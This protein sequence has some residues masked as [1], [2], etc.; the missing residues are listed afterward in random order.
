ML[1]TKDNIDTI[2]SV[3]RETL[4]D[5]QKFHDLLLKWQKAVN[6]IS[7]NTTG[8]VWHRHIAD[9]VQLFKYIPDETK[10]IADIGSG[11]GFPAIILAILA[12][13]L[14]NSADFHITMIE[15]DKKK[16]L[17]LKECVRELNL[18]ATV[19]NERIEKSSGDFDLVTARALASMDKLLEFCHILNVK[20]CLF[21]KG[22]AYAD[23]ITEA[24]ANW[25]FNENT[26]PSLTSTDSHIIKINEF[27]KK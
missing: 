23:E 16:C 8:E 4:E 9:S 3:S 13:D 19:H 7:P 22:R 27:I 11:G 14:Q 2:Y 15:S 24:K 20:S 26:I 18:N 1:Y 21:L 5:L 12:K 6:L 25:A 10:S 17:F